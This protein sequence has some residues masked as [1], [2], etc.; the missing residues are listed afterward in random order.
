[1]ID[2]AWLF[3]QKNSWSIVDKA[4]RFCKTSKKVKKNVTQSCLMK[5]LLKPE[6]RACPC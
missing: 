3:S 2:I 6:L 1:M 4:T 5:N